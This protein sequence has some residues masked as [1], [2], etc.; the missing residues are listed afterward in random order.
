MLIKIVNGHF[1]YSIDAKVIDAK[2]S[3]ISIRITGVV[4]VEISKK[5][6]K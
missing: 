6:K 3:H 2:P 5:V 4:P 1:P